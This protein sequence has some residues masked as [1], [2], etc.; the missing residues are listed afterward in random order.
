MHLALHLLEYLL[1]QW[2]QHALLGS[3]TPLPS[4][5]ILQLLGVISPATFLSHFVAF[6][7]SPCSFHSIRV[8]SVFLLTHIFKSRIPLLCSHHFPTSFLIAHFTS[9][10]SCP[11]TAL[12]SLPERN[13]ATRSV[14][15]TS[16]SLFTDWLCCGQTMVFG[17][18]CVHKS[19]SKEFIWWICCF[20]KGWK[21]VGWCCLF[22]LCSLRFIIETYIVLLYL[23]KYLFVPWSV[24]YLE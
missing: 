3:F 13:V 1:L 14:V 22:Y 15:C 21:S 18:P 17:S 8:T 11:T 7:L 19:F 2:L 9:L 16:L 23:K 24:L 12:S 6:P 20:D 4:K 5:R 10:S